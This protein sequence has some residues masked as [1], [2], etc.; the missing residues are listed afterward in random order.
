MKPFLSDKCNRTSKI[1][2]AHN[3]NVISDD[4]ELAKKSKNFLMQWMI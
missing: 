1:Y 3:G 4:F 2:F